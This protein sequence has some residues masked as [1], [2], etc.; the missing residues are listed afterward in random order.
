MSYNI[1][2]QKYEGTK[3]NILFDVVGCS[4]NSLSLDEF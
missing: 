3:P 1:I 4:L 2:P